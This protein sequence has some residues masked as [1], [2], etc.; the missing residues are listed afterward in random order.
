MRLRLSTSFRILVPRYHPTRN[1]PLAVKTV[2]RCLDE[3]WLCSLM[4]ERISFLFQTKQSTRDELQLH[5][6]RVILECSVH[7]RFRRTNIEFS[8][9]VYPK[10]ES[11]PICGTS[12]LIKKNRESICNTLRHHQLDLLHYQNKRNSPSTST[13]KHFPVL[14]LDIPLSPVCIHTKQCL[15][16]DNKLGRSTHTPY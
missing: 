5:D 14:F 16:N 8:K 6:Q 2:H 15:Q 7:L 1:G 10:F 3:Q 12:S 9:H 11:V 13:I 4:F